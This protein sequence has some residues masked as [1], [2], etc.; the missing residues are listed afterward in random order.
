MILL[1]KNILSS[2]YLFLSIGVLSVAISSIFIKWATAPASVLAMYRLLLTVLFLLPF[3][4]WSIIN[5]QTNLNKKDFLHLFFSSLF[6]A[7]HFLF[8]M[9][10]LRHT[11][12]ASSMII[13]SLSP[14]FTTIGLFFFFKARTTIAKVMSLVIAILGSLII[15][16]GDIGLSHEALYGDFLSLLGCIAYAVHLLFGQLLVQKISGQ[17]YSF[18]V[19]L[20]SGILL[21]IYNIIFKVELISYSLTNWLIFILLAFFSTILGHMLFNIC[22]K[23]LDASVV[24]M[25][26][27][28]EP[29]LA[30]FLAFLLLGEEI[31]LLQITGSLI[32]V[33]GIGLFFKPQKSKRSKIDY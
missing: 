33:I 6:L 21:F 26:T 19:F 32:T 31:T 7:L 25:A 12:V 24:S 30:I 11:S 2:P 5:K 4:P 8:W 15:A 23:H 3:K 9:E 29:I 27:I 18:V 13:L 16:W 22:L 14:V 17:S 1:R 28:G 20:I 10:S